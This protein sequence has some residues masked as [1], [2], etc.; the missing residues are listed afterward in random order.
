MCC[1]REFLVVVVLVVVIM[2]F[3]IK[4]LGEYWINVAGESFYLE[5]FVVLVGLCCEDVV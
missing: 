1:V 4:G 2:F 5:S 3:F